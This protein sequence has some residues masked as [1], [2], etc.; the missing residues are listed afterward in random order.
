MSKSGTRDCTVQSSENTVTSTV[1]YSTVRKTSYV[2]F[3]SLDISGKKAND[4]VRCRTD[5]LVQL[6]KRKKYALKGTT[7][8]FF[9]RFQNA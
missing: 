1:H 2:Q 4:I 8:Q 5:R 3:F 6:P 7:H 9:T